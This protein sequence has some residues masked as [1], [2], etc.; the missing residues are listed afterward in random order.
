MDRGGAAARRGRAD[1]LNRSLE[2]DVLDRLL[3]DVPSG[4]SGVL[5]IR[6]EPGIGKT[7][8]IRYAVR[9]A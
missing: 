4:Q 6:G 5:V 9:Q 7:A 2:R 3:A 1:L 8:L